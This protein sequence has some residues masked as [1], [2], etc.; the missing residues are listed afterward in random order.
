MNSATETVND[1]LIIRPAGRIDSNTAPQFEQDVLGPING[2]QN[3]VVLD[4][5]D[6]DYISSAGLR[7][8]LMAAK[9]LKPSGGKLALYGMSDPIR[10]VFEISGFLTLLTVCADRDEALAAVAD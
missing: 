8:V 5:G 10:E 4:F 2:G 3:R 6:L 7:V 9:R 1:T